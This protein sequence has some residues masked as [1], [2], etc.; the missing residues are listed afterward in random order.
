[1]P[2]G[3]DWICTCNNIIFNDVIYQFIVHISNLC[4]RTEEEEKHKYKHRERKRI[5][6]KC[7]WS[8]CLM[9]KCTCD[10]Y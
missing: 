7:E 3:V 5:R 8:K 6:P 10:I 9:Y 4:V 2:D 1:M